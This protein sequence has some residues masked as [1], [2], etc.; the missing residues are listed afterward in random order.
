MKNKSCATCAICEP[1]G[2]CAHANQGVN[3]YW[4]LVDKRPLNQKGTDCARYELNTVRYAQIIR[5]TF[6]PQVVFDTTEFMLKETS[7]RHL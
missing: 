6:D 3:E 7:G 1:N 4:C 2:D 5:P